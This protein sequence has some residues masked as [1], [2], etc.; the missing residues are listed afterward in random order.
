MIKNQYTIN[1]RDVTYFLNENLL[2]SKNK[3]N[4]NDNRSNFYFLDQFN[5]DVNKEQLKGQGVLVI[6]NFGLPKS[7]K[8]YFSDGI[9]NLKT[10]TFVAGKTKIEADKKIFDNENQDPRLIGVS[11]KGKDN[12]IIVNK[13]SL[14]VAI[15]MKIALLGLYMLKK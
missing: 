10:K 2:S 1:S 11:S 7:D 13:V 15:I 3:S 6:T 4:I 12:K 5:F 8:I 14:L 9:F